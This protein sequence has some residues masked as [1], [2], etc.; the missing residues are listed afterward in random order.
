M[1]NGNFYWD[2]LRRLRENIWCKHPDKWHNNSCTFYHD[3]AL[4][5]SLLVVL[6]FLASAKTTVV[7]HPPYSLDLAPCEFFLFLKMKLK[8]KGR[9][10]D[11][12][13]EIQ[14]DLQDVMKMLT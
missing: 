5:H 14:T 6:Q 4:V 12:I 13:E 11:I 3:K 2:V 7:P 9:C 10:F 8:L 1:V